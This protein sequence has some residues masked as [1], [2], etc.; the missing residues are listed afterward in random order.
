ML[1]ISPSEESDK[2]KENF[3]VPTVSS[4]N[5]KCCNLAPSCEYDD[6]MSIMNTKRCP[7]APCCS[8]ENAELIHNDGNCCCDY[9]MMDQ[10]PRSRPYLG[11]TVKNDPEPEVLPICVTDDQSNVTGGYLEVCVESSVCP[12]NTT[13]V[14]EQLEDVSMMG[15]CCCAPLKIAAGL[16]FT[17]L[18]FKNK[19]SLK[20]F[21]EKVY[22][23]VQ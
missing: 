8:G 12:I 13:M 18:Q 14:L 21:L 6:N 15:R 16:S 19:Y 7:T 23:E 4:R 20:K 22:N 17:S 9:E 1:V 2:I 3:L 5:K 11:L 10:G